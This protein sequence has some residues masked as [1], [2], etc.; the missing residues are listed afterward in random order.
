[1]F[2]VEKD[3]DTNQVNFSKPSRTARGQFPPAGSHHP[4]TQE[5]HNLRFLSFLDVDTLLWQAQ[6]QFG[7]SSK[8]HFF[9]FIAVIV[10]SLEVDTLVSVR[11]E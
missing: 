8:F 11:A 6:Q 3:N 2:S 7:K 5:L 9:M 1:M 10:S 4:F